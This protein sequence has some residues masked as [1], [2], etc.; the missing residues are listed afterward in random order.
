MECEF[1]TINSNTEELKEIFENTKT[2]AV[3][4]CSPNEEKASNRVANYLK[5]AGFKMV[6]VYPKEDEILG[7]KVYRSLKE[8]PF[9]VDMVDIF[10]KPDVIA[11]VVD[12]CIERGDIDTVWT[13]LG[14]VNNE[15]AAKAKEK[16]MKVVQ[17]KCTKIEHNN[18][19]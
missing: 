17:N 5:N 18:I 14:L 16:G 13:Q 6:P 9:K 7:E 19:F 2:I 1:P 3:I 4:G 11:Q 15:A 12:E 8:I 10:R